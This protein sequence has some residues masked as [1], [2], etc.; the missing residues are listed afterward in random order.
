[1]SPPNENAVDHPSSTCHHDGMGNDA[2]RM[3]PEGGA[4][5]V[6]DGSCVFC[7]RSMS[8]IAEHDSARRIRFTACTSDVGSVLVLKHA[9]DP[10]DSSKFLVLIDDVP[11]VR[12]EAML[13]LVPLLDRRVRPLAALRMVPTPLRD[14]I[15]D[16]TARNRLRL[17]GRTECP[18]PSAAMRERIIT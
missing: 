1:M 3:I 16:W 4:L 5:I 11:Y 18:I 2:D 14:A 6:Y 10:A 7:S 9:I 8:W 13:R 15:Y 12:S 17:M